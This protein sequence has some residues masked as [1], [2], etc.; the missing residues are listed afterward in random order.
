MYVLSGSNKFELQKSISE[1]LAGRYGI[2]EMCSLS[3]IEQQ[4]IAEC[5]FTPDINTL[6]KKESLYKK[7]SIN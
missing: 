5:K 2:I 4:E 1:S 6:K 3:N 7:H